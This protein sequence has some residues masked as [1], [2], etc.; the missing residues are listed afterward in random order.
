MALPNNPRCWGVDEPHAFLIRIL[1]KHL[2]PPS[3]LTIDSLPQT[4]FISNVF[5]A[6]A[7]KIYQKEDFAIMIIYIFK[8]L[9]L[10]EQQH[11][12]SES[13]I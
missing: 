10:L 4:S 3:D 11:A 12:D 8:A 7:L 2:T 13:R 5:K 1:I 6:K 9:T